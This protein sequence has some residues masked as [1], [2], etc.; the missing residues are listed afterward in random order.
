MTNEQRCENCRFFPEPDKNGWA[1]CTEYSGH[2]NGQLSK[3]TGGYCHLETPKCEKWQAKE[4]E[5]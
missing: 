5:Q 3:F 4:V 2:W 1:W